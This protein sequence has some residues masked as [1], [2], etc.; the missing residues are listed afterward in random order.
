MSYDTKVADED[1]K[2]RTYENSAEARR[3]HLVDASGNPYTTL[4]PLPVDTELTLDG[5]VIINNM[6]ITPRGISGRTYTYEDTSF[7]TGDSPIVLDVNTDLGRNG[8]DGYIINDG[9][10]DFTVEFSDDGASYGSIHT[11]KKG[12]VMDLKF[13][14]VDSIRITWIADSAYRVLVV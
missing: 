5:N 2:Q 12:E 6:A 11:I 7:V 14:D 13:L 9:A 8:V 3:V 4:S 1:Q 10:G